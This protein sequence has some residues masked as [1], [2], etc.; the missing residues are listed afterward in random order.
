MD[1]K[2]FQTLIYQYRAGKISRGRFVIEWK[3]EQQRQGAV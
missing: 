2:L 1:Y 3:A